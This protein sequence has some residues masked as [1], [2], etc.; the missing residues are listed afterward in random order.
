[1]W[2]PGKVTP[3]QVAFYVDLMKKVQATPEWKEYIESSSQTDTF[4]TGDDFA[5][6]HRRG[7][8]A[9]AQGRGRGGLARRQL[10]SASMI[11]RGARSRPATAALTGAFG[12]AVAV[13]A[14]RTAS[15]G[16]APASSAGTFPFIT[17]LII[18]AGSLLQSRARAAARQPRPR[19]RL[20]RAQAACRACSCRP[21]SSSPRSRSSGCTSRR[22][23]LHASARLRARSSTASVAALRLGVIALRRRR[24]VLAPLSSCSSSML[25]GLAAARRCLGATALGSLQGE[26]PSGKSRRPP[27]RLL[28]RAHAAAPRADGRAACCSASWSACCRGSAR[29]TASR[30]CCR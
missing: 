25:P 13:P 18:V 28:D 12:V 8:R 4:L 30:C 7:H 26:A 11:S 24:S 14:S 21:P 29:R 27:A 10:T 16:R 5:E 17:G 2:L 1:M 23:A 22:R 15:A 20:G 3:D 6:V 9:R 19:D